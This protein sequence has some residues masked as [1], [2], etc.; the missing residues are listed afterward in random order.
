MIEITAMIICFNMQVYGSNVVEQ[1]SLRT[2]RGG[3]L[4]VE[5]GPDGVLLPSD[6]GDESCIGACFKAGDSRVSRSD[7]K[8]YTSCTTDSNPGERAAQFVRSAHNLP[9]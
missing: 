8:D 5:Q 2:F 7:N 6:K 3:R 1:R 9:A 4:S